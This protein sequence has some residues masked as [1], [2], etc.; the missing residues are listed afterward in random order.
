MQKMK[1][2]RIQSLEDSLEREIGTSFSILA[3][4][5]PWI[6]YSPWSRKESDTTERLSIHTY[7]LTLTAEGQGARRQLKAPE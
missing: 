4:K 2:T 6:E 7:G 3:W 5:I 1:E